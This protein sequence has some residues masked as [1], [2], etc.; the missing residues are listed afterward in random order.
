MAYRPPLGADPEKNQKA[1]FAAIVFS[2]AVNDMSSA[3][4]APLIAAS[5]ALPK[6]E[7]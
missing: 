4:F 3:F 5:L 7:G 1:A 2:H 6:E